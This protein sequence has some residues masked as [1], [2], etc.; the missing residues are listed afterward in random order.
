MRWHAVILALLLMGATS[1]AA[2]DQ[3]A[4]EKDPKQQA[5]DDIAKDMRDLPSLGE[6]RLDEVVSFSNIGG[7]LRPVTRLSPTGLSTVR[8]TG[9]HGFAT[10]RVL[11]RET[12]KS[13]GA[14]RFIEFS[15]RDLDV[16]GTI[17][18]VTEVDCGPSTVQISRGMELPGDA[19]LQVQLIRSE[20]TDPH[21]II[22]YIQTVPPSGMSLP[23][24]RISAASLADLARKDPPDVDVYL[25][26][27][28]RMFG[29]EQVA[30][31]VEDKAACQVLADWYPVDPGV[32]AAT[33]AAV[34]GLGAESFADREAALQR[35]RDLGEPAAIH[36]MTS[37]VRALNDEQTTRV[38]LFLAPYRPFTD[39]Q[40]QRLRHDPDFLLDCL[41]N[42]DPTIRKLAL[43]QCRRSTR[44]PINLDLNL[45]GSALDDAVTAVRQSLL[46]SSTQP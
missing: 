21:S 40:A 33:D 7:M 8:L 26:P 22:L 13:A 11:S 9:L 17:E 32:A 31:A 28:F 29:A 3:P 37:S 16:P 24:R 2:A 35:L 45:T 14:D 34:D 38:E 25:R 23:A 42:S 27:I 36:L 18:V 12:I 46:N 5:R 1:A 20:A 43:T 4:A 15:Y 44:Q 39:E 41:F 6:H 30:F 19:L 10:V